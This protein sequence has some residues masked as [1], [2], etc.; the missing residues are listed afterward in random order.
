MYLASRWRVSVF[1]N[2]RLERRL[3]VDKT[4]YLP[5]PRN[6][7]RSVFCCRPSR[8][9]MSLTVSALDAFLSGRTEFFQ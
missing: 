7:V 2:L 8:F 4:A 5:M 3:H 9:G 6:A 1:E